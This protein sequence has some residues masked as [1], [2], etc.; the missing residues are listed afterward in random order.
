MILGIA[1]AVAAPT[2]YRSLRYHQV[3][4][5]ARRLKLDL[6]QIRHTARVRS[7]GQSITFTGS[8]YTLST[9]VEN[10]DHAGE[11]Y[12]VDLAA[13]PFELDSVTIDFGGPTAITFDGFGA[14]SAGGTIVLSQGDEERTVTLDGST[15]QVTISSE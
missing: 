9:D 13:S 10:L 6:E 11:S 3:E 8:S 12:A 2:F 7:R 1:A 15:G 5:A 4:S 14:P